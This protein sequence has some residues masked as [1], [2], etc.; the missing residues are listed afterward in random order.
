M[1][2]EGKKETKKNNEIKRENEITGVLPKGAT[3]VG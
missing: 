3:L 2:V 1:D